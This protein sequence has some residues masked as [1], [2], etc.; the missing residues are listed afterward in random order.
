M[1]QNQIKASLTFWLGSLIPLVA[2]VLTGYFAARK[3]RLERELSMRREI[4]LAAVEAADAGM[5]AL[6]QFANPDISDATRLFREKASSITKVYLVANLEA[7]KTF[8]KF[9]DELEA[10]LLR[11]TVRRFRLL[12]KKQQADTDLRQTWANVLDEINND[13]DNLGRLFTSVLSAFRAELRLPIEETELHRIF[14]EARK[15]RR[16]FVEQISQLQGP[17]A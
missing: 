9:R 12:E 15:N 14:D 16:G 13:A 1:P 11:A 5:M 10:A 4:Y 3:A 8:T 17:A 2:V 6:W 7:V